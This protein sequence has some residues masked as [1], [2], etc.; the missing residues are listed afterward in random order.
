ME[1]IGWNA[2]K[3][4]QNLESVEP[5]LPNSMKT[6]KETAFIGNPKLVGPLR[7]GMTQDIQIGNQTFEDCQTIQVV[8]LGSGVTNLSYGMFSKCYGI[9]EIYFYGNAPTFDGRAQVFYNWGNRQARFFIP[10][11]N[12]AW[13]TAM[14]AAWMMTPLD[15]ISTPTDLERYQ[16]TYGEEATLPIGKFQH[17]AQSSVTPS[18]WQWFCLWN[19]PRNPNLIT[20]ITIK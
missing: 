15:E 7:L 1:S 18:N 12:P 13:E 17:G 4:C 11:G 10:R 20:V 14:A 16:E 3:G 9:K 5:F 2:I 19:P 6:I 8:H